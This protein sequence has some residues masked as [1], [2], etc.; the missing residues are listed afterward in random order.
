M[1]ISL[2]R[3]VL[4]E[5]HQEALVAD[6]NVQ[7]IERLHRVE[8]VG[9]RKLSH[10]GDIPRSTHSCNLP[11]QKRHFGRWSIAGGSLTKNYIS[12]KIDISEPHKPPPL[13]CG[14]EGQ[15]GQE[16]TNDRGSRT[17]CEFYGK[18]R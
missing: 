4:L 13:P 8:L 3:H 10:S 6:Q 18:W 5:L 16:M 12:G 7:R 14:A 1:K 2:G 11:A 9:R 15:Q 17:P